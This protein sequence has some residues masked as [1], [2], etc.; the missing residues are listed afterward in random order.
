MTDR[1]HS[2]N[3]PKPL[4]SAPLPATAEI[5]RDRRRM[6]INPLPGLT[7]VMLVHALDAFERGDL[8]ECVLLWEKVAER[9]DVISGVKPKREKDVSQ[10]DRQITKLAACPA[11]DDH[12]AILKDFWDGAR[13]VNYYDRNESGGF[14]RLVKQMMSAVSYKYAAHHIVWKPGA[15]GRLRAEF[16]FVPLW[17]FE[18]LTGRLRFLRNPNAREGEELA[19][20]DWMVTHGDGLML[21]CSIGYLA[22]RTA[23]NDW[24]IFSEKFSVPG[25]LGRTTARPGSEAGDAMRQA[26]EAFGHDWQGVIYGDDG[27]HAEPI[28]IIQAA[29]NPTGMPMPA[30]I[31][32]VDRRFASL[33]RGADLSTMSAGYGEGTGASLQAKETDILR[34]DDAEMIAE[35][36]G[37]VSRL[38]LEWHYGTGVEPLARIELV[39]PVADDAAAVVASGIKLA[40]AG[41]PVSASALMERAG[42][43]AATDDAD[44]L[45]LPGSAA[46]SARAAE[47]A[48]N[49]AAPE[50]PSERPPWFDALDADTRP[51]ADAL[52]AAMQAGDMAAMKR[53]L[54]KISAGLP[55]YIAGPV[56]EAYVGGEFENA[57]K[58]S[59]PD[60]SE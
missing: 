10:L 53:A 47:A 14:R 23:F 60:L 8:R 26:V 7:P 6:R 51:L 37:Q 2:A 12:A 54:D 49:A 48:A 9:D 25:V 24:L 59:L 16:E 30:V 13:C 29:G 50:P 34:R 52:A 27:A 58:E 17:M 39:A 40:A 31:E 32:R 11:A 18:N 43:P 57:V 45:F 1:Q 28:K 21:P 35:T 15:G 22:K 42:I 46:A 19:P 38:V 44:R 3:P 33:Y 20:G 5:L 56:F 36:M 55:N 4:F 41:A